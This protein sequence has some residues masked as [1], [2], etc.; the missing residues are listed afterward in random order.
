MNSNTLRF[1]LVSILIIVVQV[2]VLGPVVLFGVATPFFYPVVLCLLPLGTGPIRL[3]WV[4]FVIG[5]ILDLLM[6]TPGL[7]AFALTLTSFL[8][9]YL[10]RPMIDK[11]MNMEH[12][13]LYSTL[14]GGAIFLLIELLVIHHILLYFLDAGLHFDLGRLLVSL[15]IGVVYSFVCAMVVFL[16]LSIR[17]R[18]HHGQ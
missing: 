17:L 18:P 12:L 14:Q 7:H 4:G 11:N 6:L 1:I 10:L 3:T 2:W 15:G 13:P 8:R 5:S 16:A 9:Y